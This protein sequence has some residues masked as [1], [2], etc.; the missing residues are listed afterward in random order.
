LTRDVKDLIGVDEADVAVTYHLQL[1]LGITQP[2]K[3]HI[4]ISIFQFPPMQTCDGAHNLIL[5]EVGCWPA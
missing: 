3:Q 1:H 4:I 2:K 5:Y